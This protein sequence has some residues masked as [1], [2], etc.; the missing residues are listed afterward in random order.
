M[1]RGS[2][3][4][5]NYDW[6]K[7]RNHYATLLLEMLE[8]GKLEFPFDKRPEEGP[9][10]TLPTYLRP[11]ASGG[12]VRAEKP[13]QTS[14]PESARRRADKAEDVVNIAS[15]AVDVLHEH[16]V[17]RSAASE[18]DGSGFGYRYDAEIQ[19]GA[20][21]ERCLELEMQVN[22]KNDQIDR[23]ERK[24][25]KARKAHEVDVQRYRGKVSSPFNCVRI[26]C[27]L[28]LTS[29]P[30]GPP[31]CQQIQ[32]LKDTY[33]R[34]LGEIIKRY[35]A[36]FAQQKRR[37]V[38]KASRE[39]AAP[40]PPRQ[41]ARQDLPP[42]SRE[43]PRQ[44]STFLS[45]LPPAPFALRF[46]IL[47]ISALLFLPPLSLSAPNEKYVGFL[48]NLKNQMQVLKRNLEEEQAVR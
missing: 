45:S 9:L 28:W 18:A 6:K 10:K 1:A 25:V 42:E 16:N 20:C 22:A 36:Y 32:S 44:V 29:P 3:Q 2:R 47:T 34:N 37:A 19:L 23:L 21:R 26:C 12:V 41:A 38:T 35:T 14:R 4:T 31:A 48:E 46:A 15:A 33:T 7:N 8:S 43:D 27:G 39:A 13:K 5:S 17:S 24:L 30:P 11:F 40:L